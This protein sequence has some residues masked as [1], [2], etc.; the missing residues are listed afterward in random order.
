MFFRSYTAIFGLACINSWRGLWELLDL[1]AGKTVTS[2]SLTISGALLSLIILKGVRNIT[3]TPMI[4]ATDN[5]K[6]YFKIS[7]QYAFQVIAPLR[8]YVFRMNPLPH[9]N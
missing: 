2:T 9:Q 8:H 4:L 5:P 6:D 3:S 1:Y 7:T